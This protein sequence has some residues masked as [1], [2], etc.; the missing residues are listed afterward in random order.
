MKIR[1]VAFNNRKKSFEVVTVSETLVFPYVKA[2]PAPAPGDPVAQVRV[3][4]ELAREAFVFT[5]DSGRET[6]VHSKYSVYRCGSSG[7]NRN[8][9]LRNEVWEDSGEVRMGARRHAGAR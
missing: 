7:H 6:T 8:G 1:A 4:D 3:D 9:V 5:V 2:D